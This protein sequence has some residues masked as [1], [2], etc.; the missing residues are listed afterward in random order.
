MNAKADFYMHESDRKALQAL[1]AIPGFS[2]VFKAFLN[3]WDE[4]QYR[5]ENVS[6]NLRIT[7]KQMPKYYNMLPP[8]CEKLGIEVPELYLKLDVNANA[9][10]W[11]DTQPF[12][13][14]TSGLL[15]TIPEELIPTVL[16]HE[17]GHIACHHC[18]YTTIGQF[19]LNGAINTLRL[20]DIAIFP[21]QVAF[22][23]WMRC[24]ELS[25]DRA[26]A[27]YCGSS[28]PVEKM[29]MCFAGYDKDITGQASLEEFMNQAVEY[30]EMVSADKWNKTLEFL[31]FSKRDHPLNA[32]RA[33]E[34]HKWAET[35]HFQKLSAY[36]NQ[37]GLPESQSLV[38]YMSEVPMPVS[39]KEYVGQSK[40]E[41]IATFQNLGFQNI[42][43]L[44]MTQ[45]GLMVKDG[46]VLDV[47]INGISGF[48]M[49]DWYPIDAEIVV[50]YYEH[51]TEEEV[52]AAHPGQRRVPYA[53]KKCLGRSYQEVVEKLRDAGFSVI[54]LTAQHKGKKGFLSKEGEI[55]HISI[56]GQTQFEEGEWFGEK[57]EITITYLT[58]D[59]AEP[60]TPKEELTVPKQKGIPKVPFFKNGKS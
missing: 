47:L 19:I 3:V 43:T 12:I 54:K 21:I 53:S 58:F 13:V 1:K 44:K 16:A 7:E 37:E 57:S 55:S 41:A 36:V 4:R 35:E 56:S 10:T 46:Q 28:Q 34:C 31:L 26:A 50:E 32:V 52:A 17:C 22:S 33:Y 30:Q 51:E 48:E 2:Q 60:P 8:I 40:E 5:I 23:Y 39:V 49:C 59:K 20:G 9:Y 24:S 11:G 29:C 45:K 38:A 42:K 18:L 25:A 15:E 14:M 27:L 6:S